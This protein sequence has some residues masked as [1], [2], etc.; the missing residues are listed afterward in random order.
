[1]TSARRRA[2][3]LTLAFAAAVLA[4]VAPALAAAPPAQAELPPRPARWWPP[5]AGT[6]RVMHGFA[7]PAHPWL[8]GHRGV[9]LAAH[10]GSPVRAAGSG[11]VSVAGPVA[12]VLVVAIRHPNGLET[13]YEPVR[14]VVRRGQ[15]V[16][17]GEVLGT[18]VLAG[19]HC[20]RAA[21]LHWGLL[22]HGPGGV[23]YLDPLGL[24]GRARVRLL[25]LGNAPPSWAPPL[26][27]G[28]ATGSALTWG[29]LA[30][31]AARRR[32]RP[33]PYGVPS[34]AAARARRSHGPRP[35]EHEVGVP[36]ERRRE[37]GYG[38]RQQRSSGHPRQP[39]RHRHQH[40]ERH[41][42]KP[43]LDVHI[44][45]LADGHDAGERGVGD[46]GGRRTAAQPQHE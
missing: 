25:P 11:V 13:T 22:R 32:R 46:L 35:D 31:R 10:A 26:A 4:L 1:M 9:D 15:V 6:L 34:L 28:A 17:A 21:C 38:E 20:R 5:L 12:G 2:V 45:A 7:P 44:V 8:P 40:R 16:R 3:V 30:G 42:Q 27:G 29:A 14:A 18:L 36:R 41:E 24:L 33:P 43:G 23:V 37:H 19:G 39:A